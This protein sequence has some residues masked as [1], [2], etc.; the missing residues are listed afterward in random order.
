MLAGEGNAVDA[1]VAAAA[2]LCVVLPDACGLGGDVLL[3]IGREGEETVAINGNGA[4]PAAV[5]A[6][7]PADGGGTAAVPG[8][9][10]GLL[11]AHDRFGVLA[12][13]Q[14]LAPAVLLARDGW[15]VSDEVIEARELQRA[16]LER[17]A[18]GWALL[19]PAIGPGDVARLPRLAELIAAIGTGGATAFY[20]GAAAS[21]VAAA[22]REDGGAMDA[23]DLGVYRADVRAPVAAGFAGV[24]CEVSPPSSQGI[25][26]LVALR[27]LE[28]LERSG[29]DAPRLHLQLRAI[30][31]CFALR[32]DVARDDAEELLLADSTLDSLSLEPTG[33]GGGPRGYNHTTSVTAADGDGLVVSGLASVFDDFGSATLVPELDLLLNSRLLGFDREGPN[34]P[35]PGRRP[36]HTLAPALITAPDRLVALATPGAD[37]QIQTLLQVISA[38]HQEG[39]ELREVLQRPRWRAI[40]GGVVVEEGFD[41]D[42]MAELEARGH[43]V[44]R[45]PA[46]GDLFGALA[47]TTAHSGGGLEAVSDPRRETWAGAV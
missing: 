17:G 36:V 4:A 27:W 32:S 31:E 46:G 1:A 10:A 15:P 21:A 16:R 22:A 47:S 28:K 38:V 19:D 34:S 24:R 26:L 44:E 43:S 12:L 25:L 9:V 30:E 13:E 20:E 8:L 41:E 37:G 40:N 45:L 3:L 11:E 33:R 6:E 7:I 23:A 18:A 29:I 2:A 35:A 39:A 14:V 42:L 5:P